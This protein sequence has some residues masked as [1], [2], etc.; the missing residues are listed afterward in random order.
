V[1]FLHGW[2][3]SWLEFERVMA[4]LSDKA[5]FVALDLPGIGG[6]VY[7][8][9][10]GDKRAIAAVVHEVIAAMTLEDVSL[11][12]H[13]I[14]GQVAFAHLVAYPDEIVGVVLVDMAI[15]GVEPWGDV[16]GNPK[17]WHLA[18]HSIPYLPE[19]MVRGRERGCFDFFYEAVN[20]HPESI[21][22]DARA[23]S[24]VAYLT[25]GAL[26]ASFGWYRGFSQDTNDN[27]AFAAD[28]RRIATPLL[29]VQGDKSG[30]DLERYHRGF[31]GA[32]IDTVSGA[33]VPG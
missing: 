22:D 8:S 13:D 31:R 4:L 15:H 3:Q 11:V 26:T 33:I 16:I 12:G 20:A 30:G 9:A 21:D 17:V 14:G 24:V 6:S 27:A 32:G 2:P 23:S 10:P 29:Y 18:F 19:T 5:R 1:V 7:P 28:A 25:P